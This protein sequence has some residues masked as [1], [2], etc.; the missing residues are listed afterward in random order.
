MTVH[1]TYLATH[2]TK[3]AMPNSG[4]FALLLN[5]HFLS[6]IPYWRGGGQVH[7]RIVRCSVH[8]CHVKVLNKDCMVSIARYYIFSVPYIYIQNR[9]KSIAS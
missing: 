8:H 9:L 4:A 2:P 7:N 3:L 1:T 6:L 5:P